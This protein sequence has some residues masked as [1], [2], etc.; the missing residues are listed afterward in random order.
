ML[1][2][3]SLQEDVDE[4]LKQRKQEEKELAK[5]K[6]EKKTEELKN[7][8][9]KTANVALKGINSLLG[10][11]KISKL[12]KENERLQGEIANRDGQ[13]KNLQKDAEQQKEWHAE[14]IR[15]TKLQMQKTINEQERT[16]RFMVRP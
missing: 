5:V 2:G 3:K 16:I 15:Y 7:T 13:I 8:A 6:A 11:N 1:Q 14:E 4:L 10:S 9:A 12:E